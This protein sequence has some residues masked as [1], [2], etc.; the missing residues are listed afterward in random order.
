M[1]RLSGALGFTS[2]RGAVLVI[3]L[4][5]LTILG[6]LAVTSMSMGAAELAMAGNEQY[7]RAA[8]DAA[9]AGIELAIARLGAETILPASFGVQVS[10]LTGDATAS[11]RYAGRE[12]LPEVS[13]ERIAAHHYSIE[14]SGSAARQ[15]HDTQIQGVL[16]LAVNGA[17]IDY[18]G[19]DL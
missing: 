3:V 14:S 8:S 15:A 13:L 1:A 10:T 18:S 6:L 4:A 9:S 7:R 11:V 5:L 17:I 19:R 16:V 2:Q 12:A